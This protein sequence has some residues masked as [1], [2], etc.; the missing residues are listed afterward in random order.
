MRSDAIGC[1]WVGGEERGWL[2]W[3]ELEGISG[4]VVWSIQCRV[5]LEARL[6]PERG[7]HW[8]N[9]KY[10]VQWVWGVV[11]RNWRVVGIDDT[12]VVCCLGSTD[13]TE[14]RSEIRKSSTV[15]SPHAAY[16]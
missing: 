6:S 3:A 14:N 10:G 13:D 16:S 2:D 15:R 12:T 5:D 7:L 11:F 9:R 1:N 4:G 8:M